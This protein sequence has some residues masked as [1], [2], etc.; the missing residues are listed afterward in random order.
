MITELPTAFVCR[1]LKAIKLLRGNCCINKLDVI[2]TKFSVYC[3]E[4]K[5]ILINNS[6]NRIY[7]VSISRLIQL[8]EMTLCFCIKIAR[9]HEIVQLE[10]KKLIDKSVCMV[11]LT[12]TCWKIK[13]AI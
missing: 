12:I 2:F 8:K 5:G 9:M 13:S 11:F 6:R 4:N 1:A 7:I 10:V 3:K